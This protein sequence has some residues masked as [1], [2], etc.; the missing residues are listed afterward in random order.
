[1]RTRWSQ[2]Y[3]TDSGAKAPAVDL[4]S[5]TDELED[6]IHIDCIYTCS[7]WELLIILRV[8]PIPLITYYSQNYSRIIGSG[9]EGTRDKRP[10]NE[11]PGPG[12]EG[13]GY[14]GPGNQ[15]PRPQA[16]CPRP[17]VPR[18]RPLLPKPLLL[19]KMSIGI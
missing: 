13:P 12:E 1:M 16:P 3:S 2:K 9:L 17:L 19:R 7:T 4:D 14:P 11:G 6:E 8:I 15:A 10:E 5:R 18:P